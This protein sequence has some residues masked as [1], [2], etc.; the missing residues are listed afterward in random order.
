MG[1]VFECSLS[2]NR[3]YKEMRLSFKGCSGMCLTNDDIRTRTDKQRHKDKYL[4]KTARTCLRGLRGRSKEEL[5]EHI[6]R[7]IMQVNAEPVVYP[8]NG[9]LKTSSPH[10][11][12]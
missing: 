2:S 9:S 3:L 6:N 1:C 11:L 5:V 10:L 7:W 4:G 8:G 12:N